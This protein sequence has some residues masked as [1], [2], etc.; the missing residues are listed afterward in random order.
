[1][2]ERKKEPNDLKTERDL[3]E[4]SI[5]WFSALS[6]IRTGKLHHNTVERRKPDVRFGKPE[7]KASGFRTSGFRTS[8]V[9]YIPPD[10]ECPNWTTGGLSK[11][12]KSRRPDF[13]ALLYSGCPKSKQV[14]LDVGRLPL[15]QIS[16][17]Y[18]SH[19]YVQ[20][21]TLA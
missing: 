1:M 6:E 19:T 8:E 18:W 17:L 20:N 21:Q 2:F 4:Q 7:E 11:T 10:F 13:G 14:L 3:L 9:Y 16:T 15:V 12:P 5:V